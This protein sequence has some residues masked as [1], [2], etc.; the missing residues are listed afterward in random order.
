[1]TILRHEKRAD[2]ADI[3]EETARQG[4][5]AMP[6]KIPGARLGE[7]NAMVGTAIDKMLLLRGQPNSITANANDISALAAVAIMDL[8]KRFKKSVDEVLAELHELGAKLPDGLSEQIR[9]AD[10]RSTTTSENA[11]ELSRRRSG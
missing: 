9:K 1:V 6:D 5:A 4:F 11:S 8:A 3:C 2:L 7:V 10:S